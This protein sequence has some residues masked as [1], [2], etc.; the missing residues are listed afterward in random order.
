[1]FES[2]IVWIAGFKGL[3]DGTVR[4]Y[5]MSSEGARM[6]AMKPTREAKAIRRMM[7]Q[8]KGIL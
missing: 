3:G 2:S 6:M 1:M 7:V 5:Q 8:A 4:S